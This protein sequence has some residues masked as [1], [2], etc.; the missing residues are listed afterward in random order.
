[1]YLFTKTKKPTIPEVI[2]INKPRY[3]A[4]LSGNRLCATEEDIASLISF[5]YEYAASPLALSP[6]TKF[7]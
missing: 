5:R 7:M 3:P 6:A 1:M 2:V 4:S